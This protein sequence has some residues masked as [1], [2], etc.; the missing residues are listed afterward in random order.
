MG[1]SI[2]IGQSKTVFIKML[3]ELT[4]VLLL[5]SGALL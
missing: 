4:K 2:E 1:H 5:I 3:F